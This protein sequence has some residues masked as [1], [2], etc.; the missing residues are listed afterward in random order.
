MTRQLGGWWRL[1]IVLTLIYG[2]AVAGFTWISWPEVSR[3]PHDPAFLKQMSSDA[4]LILER[5]KTLSEL[6]S[7]L[8][9]ADRAK[10][11]EFARELAQKIVRLREAPKWQQDPIVLEM[12]N[13]HEFQVAGDTPSDLSKVVAREYVRVLQSVASE[14]KLK[15]LGTAVLVWLVPSV[16][17]C[18]L[19]LAVAWVIRGFRGARREP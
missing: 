12:P 9:E 6:E 8:V 2:C 18:A 1:W 13:G 5:P 17:V 7:A 10:N 3:V 4:V 16:V 14:R 11:T 19:G 15:S